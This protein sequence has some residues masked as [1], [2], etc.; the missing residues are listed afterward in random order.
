MK[1][2]LLAKTIYIVNMIL[3]EQ[4]PTY[5][6]YAKLVTAKS[7]GNFFLCENYPVVFFSRLLVMYSKK[8]H[9]KVISL[10][11][12]NRYNWI[13]ITLEGKHDGYEYC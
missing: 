6:K 3:Y 4:I 5:M 1:S 13:E 10:I 12:F 7:A 2:Q 8:Y 9:V 11:Y